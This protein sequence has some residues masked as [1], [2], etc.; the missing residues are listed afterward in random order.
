M[1]WAAMLCPFG[2]DVR[3]GAATGL[4]L[5]ALGSPA[6]GKRAGERRPGKPGVIDFAPR[7]GAG[8]RPIP[9]VTFVINDMHQ[10]LE[11]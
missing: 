6:Q 11:L 8:D 9:H 2:A 10:V 4:A 1:P 7:R 3:I 5:K